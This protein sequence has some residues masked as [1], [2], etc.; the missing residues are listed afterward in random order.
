MK[1][2][3]FLSELN[4]DDFDYV[5]PD[6]RIARFPLPV[7]D[8]SRLLIYDGITLKEDIFR[9]LP[10][11]LPEDYT[12]IFNN[13]RVV[14]AR[15]F[16][17]KPTGAV[18]E[19][20]CLEPAGDHPDIQIALQQKGSVLWNCMVGN[21]RRWKSDTLKGEFLHQG[22]NIDLL[23]RKQG[24]YPD[25]YQI[26][27]SWEPS[28]L[29]FA[30]ILHMVGSIPLPPYLK[31]NATEN[32]KKTYQTVYASVEG[33]VA[34]PTAG[35]HFTPELLQKLIQ[36]GNHVKFVTLH[37]GAG[38]FKPVGSEGISSHIMH[39]EQIVVTRELIEHLIVHTGK[40]IAV[41]TTCVR[42]LESL[43]WFGAFLENKKTSRFNLPQ[44]LPYTGEINHN[45]PVPKALE[46]ILK[47]LDH[48]NQEILKGYTQ[49]M[50]VPG[51][52]YKIINGMITN[53]H[54]P[55]ST[56]LLL[57]AAWLGDQWK[58][59]YDYALK[60]DFRFLSYGDACLFYSH[61]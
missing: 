44:Y 48:T 42:T 18:I 12:L 26:H 37:V 55:R 33:S 32:D 10:D 54:Q 46:N 11:Y 16:F 50:I 30:E 51:Y 31:R 21:A 57:I 3:E 52:P 8:Q 41:G 20:L 58:E 38:T 43:Y 60:N 61:Q 40:I 15:L 49:L 17:Q 14:N 23:A 39:S 6:N 13:T 28:H 34:A 56:L 27:F 24:R 22:Q 19:I 36:R 9:N 45:L 1:I 25:H 7:R 47:W 35:L 29:S 5:L 2:P 59:I 53:F 4:I